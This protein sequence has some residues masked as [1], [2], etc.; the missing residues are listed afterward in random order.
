MSNPKIA[1]VVGIL[2]T[3]IAS[4]ATD[5]RDRAVRVQGSRGGANIST[6]V[7]RGVQQS[8]VNRSVVTDGGRSVAQSRS[9]TREP[10]EVN[11]SATRTYGNGKSVSRERGVVNNGDGSVT[12]SGQRTGANG[13]TTSRTATTAA[14]GDGGAARTITT[15]GPK[16]ETHTRQTSI[17]VDATQPAP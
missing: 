9:V 4:Q 5:A 15:T 12:A 3:G 1:L 14:T 7:Q 13:A 8:Q 6:Q 2:V 17:D 16:G 10:G 11:A